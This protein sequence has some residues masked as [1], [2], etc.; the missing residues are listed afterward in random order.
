M[1]APL[2]E[3]LTRDQGRGFDERYRWYMRS[4]NE[5]FPILNALRSELPG[6]E[7]RAPAHPEL[8]IRHAARD[9]SPALQD[10]RSVLRNGFETRLVAEDAAK[11]LGALSG[12]QSGAQSATQSTAQ[13]T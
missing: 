4:F 9:L 13:V 5:A 6:P 8:A 10:R 3:R 7:R 12:A 2:T 1:I 11:T